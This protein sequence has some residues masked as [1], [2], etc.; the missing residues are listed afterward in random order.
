MEYML[1]HIEIFLSTMLIFHLVFFITSC[2][3]SGQLFSSWKQA[4][5]SACWR[6]V[7]QLSTLHAEQGSFLIK[8]LIIWQGS[9]VPVD[10]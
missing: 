5:R 4:D 9:F 6:Y 8:D 3:I 2:L 1:E 7:I 10:A